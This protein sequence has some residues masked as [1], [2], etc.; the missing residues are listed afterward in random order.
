MY[1]Y[2]QDKGITNA[3]TRFATFGILGFFE[4]TELSG[5]FELNLHGSKRVMQALH[6]Y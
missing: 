1:F 3:S 6:A 2:Y 5:K 4:F